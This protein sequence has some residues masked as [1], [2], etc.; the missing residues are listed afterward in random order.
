[1]PK[2]TKKIYD[3]FEERYGIADFK[4]FF[5]KKTVP[6]HKHFLWYY[7]GGITLFLFCVQ[8]VTG[9]LLLFYY[10]STVAEAFESVKF[11]MTKVEFGWLIRSIHAWSANLMIFSAFIHLFSTFFLKSYRQPR[12]LTWMTGVGLLGILMGLGFT[13]YLLPWNELSFFATKVGTQIA[14]SVPIVGSYLRTVLRGGEEISDA[15]LTRFFAFHVMVLPIVIAA[16]LGIHLLMVQL[17]GMSEPLSVSRDPNKKEMKFF[18]NFLLRDF[19]VW[20][21]VFAGLL[22]LSVFFPWELGKKADPFTAT[23]VG[24][25]PEWYFLWMFQTLKFIPAKILAFD[26]EVLGILGFGV[27]GAI[28]LFIP[29]IDIWSKKEKR[30]PLFAVIG[31]LAILYILFMTYQAY[32]GPQR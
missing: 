27:A 8:V 12:E 10:K 31:I 19:L 9:I 2:L 21:L 20:L 30:N 5:A 15:T 29:F 7:F 4:D 1:M 16:F 32:F 14:G 17:Q 25:K 6:V 28:L 13:G 3:W 11:I 22:T 26:G 18:P 24:I 23:P